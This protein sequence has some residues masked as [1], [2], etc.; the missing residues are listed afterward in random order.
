MQEVDRFTDLKAYL[1]PKGYQA[2][3]A[4]KPDGVMGCAIFWKNCFE[5]LTRVKTAFIDPESGKPQNQLYL[6]GTFR[7]VETGKTLTVCTTHLKAKVPFAG[8]RKVQAKQLA[9]W[10]RTVKG[11]LLI[12][13]DF[14]ADPHEDAISEMKSCLRSA[15]E[16]VLGGEPAFTTYKYRKPTELQKRT[17]DYVFHNVKDVKG[18]LELPAESTIPSIGNPNW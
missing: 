9:D 16:D 6:H 11:P 7:H 3:F 18:W 17:I 1:Y 10:A 8:V 13:A 14:N 15:N 2:D 5:P 12:G 4:M